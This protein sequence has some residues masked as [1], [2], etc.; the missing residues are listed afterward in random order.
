M[1]QTCQ[2]CKWWTPQPNSPRGQCRRFPPH[3]RGTN[4]DCPLTAASFWCGEWAEVEKAEGKPR[5]SRP[6]KPKDTK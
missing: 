5:P 4:V 2:S 6:K 3:P 1:N